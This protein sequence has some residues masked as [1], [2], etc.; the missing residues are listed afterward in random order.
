MPGY[1][2][3]TGY[4]HA[5]RLDAEPA[6]PIAVVA[7]QLSAL[8]RQDGRRELLLAEAHLYR[9]AA[10]GKPVH[11][12]SDATGPA[13]QEGRNRRNPHVDLVTVMPWL[14]S[15]PW[16]MWGRRPAAASRAPR[17]IAGCLAYVVAGRC[18]G[19]PTALDPAFEPLTQDLSVTGATRMALPADFFM[20]TVV[21]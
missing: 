2:S 21:A 13:Q 12:V 8:A 7:H 18:P 14:R 15:C 19:T 9:P 20:V 16:R 17:T 6:D 4:S 1:V 3:Y 10:A 11:A 5:L